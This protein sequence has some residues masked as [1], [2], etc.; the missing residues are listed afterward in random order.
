MTSPPP[1]PSGSDKFP[2]D[3][4]RRLEDRALDAAAG[5]SAGEVS[6]VL[7]TLAEQGHRPPPL[8]RALCFHAA[9][10]PEPMAYKDAVR[11]LFAL[12]KLNF[13]DQVRRTADGGMA[14]RRQVCG[15]Q[16]GVCRRLRVRLLALHC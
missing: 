2:A 4:V 12:Q 5:A 3:F 6:R 14:G 15:L 9:R 7:S 16:S 10:Q 13:P 1:S 8:L 11:T